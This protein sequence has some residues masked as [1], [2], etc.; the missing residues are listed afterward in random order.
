MVGSKVWCG[1]E[2]RGIMLTF[3]AKCTG[4]AQAANAEHT[5][6]F[7]DKDNREVLRIITPEAH[8]KKEEIYSF[9]VAGNFVETET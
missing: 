6:T 5:A 1:E 2:R 9:S 4:N 3:K 8:F 7:A